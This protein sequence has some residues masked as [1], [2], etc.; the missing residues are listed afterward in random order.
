MTHKE[1]HARIG[2]DAT[3]AYFR[4]GGMDEY[5]Y[6]L[7]SH[8]EPLLAG[9]FAFSKFVSHVPF[10]TT[11]SV[12]GKDPDLLR[13]L[14]MLQCYLFSKKP[15]CMPSR[16]FPCDLFH[17][18]IH[19]FIPV[20]RKKVATIHDVS[21]LYDDYGV[22]DLFDFRMHAELMVKH[23]AHF[24]AISAAARD[25]AC[26]LLRLPE[27][28]ITIVHQGL[29][30]RYFVHETAESVEEVRARYGLSNP[31]V[32][33]VGKL[34]KRKNVPV[35]LRAF[36]LDWPAE[37]DLVLVGRE[38]NDSQAVGQLIARSP[39]KNRIKRFGFV[40]EPDL[41][42]LYQGSFACCLPSFLEGFGFT[43]LEAMASGTPVV[44][45]ANTAILETAGDAGL[46]FGTDNEGELVERIKELTNDRRRSEVVKRGDSHARNFTW[47]KCARETLGV[48]ERVL[49]GGG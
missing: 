3:F 19:M 43:I 9:R 18:T 21:F 17:M 15:A 30:P 46:L 10:V 42:A 31:Y 14:K 8:L 44:A 35:L 1:H 22:N 45:A 47:E 32:L 48:Y 40:P 23:C 16:L 12:G 26:R 39:K 13:K 28:K 20:G 5:V 37:V 24:I 38:G 2:L 4:R 49:F 41:R 7:V 29:D 6:Q 25:D 33:F 36:E 27:E 34:E 11:R